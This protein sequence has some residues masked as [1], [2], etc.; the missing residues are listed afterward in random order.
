M[1]GRYTLMSEE[2]YGDIRNIIAEV[3]RKVGE[4]LETKEIFPTQLAPVLWVGEQGVEAT[5]IRWGFPNFNRP[6]VV[7]N[8]RA[9]TAREKTMFRKPLLTSRC[10]VPATGFYE[11]NKAKEKFLFRLPESE[12]LYLAG[13][14]NQFRGQWRFTVLTTKAN[15]SMKPIHDRM[16]VILKRSQVDQWLLDSEETATFLESPSPPLLHTQI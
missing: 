3:E 8:A 6:G 15:A 16:P 9:E 10:A 2:E 13:L 4:P 11:W 1:C 12:P 7:I 5:G 14:C